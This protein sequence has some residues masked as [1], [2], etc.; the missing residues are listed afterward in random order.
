MKAEK[1]HERLSDDLPIN[2]VV[3]IAI[4]SDPYSDRGEQI[5]VL[6]SVRDDPLAGM[7]ARGQI[8]EAQM[9]AGRKWQMLHEL[10]TI[11]P[12][13]AIDPTREAVD[14][15]GMRDSI[16][17]RQVRAFRELAGAYRELGPELS[18]LV[19]DILAQRQTIGEA[20]SYRGAQ[21]SYQVRVVGSLFR[22]ALE[23]LA[24][25]WGYAAARILTSAA[26][27]L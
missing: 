16:T 4:V 2:S 21:T 12:I 24:A 3:S 25:H 17:D 26:N 7:H 10:S 9:L 13:G 15:G 20:A 11:G 6:R 1:I 27:H 14:G 18:R 5:K 22:G 23:R 19:F 8:D